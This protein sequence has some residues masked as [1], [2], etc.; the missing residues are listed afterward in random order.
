VFFFLHKLTGKMPVV[1]RWE[2]AS[3]SVDLA[4]LYW[5]MTLLDLLSIY[6]HM[7]KFYALC[8]ILLFYT[9][10]SYSNRKYKYVQVWIWV[11]LKWVTRSINYRISLNLVYS[12][13][14]ASNYFKDNAYSNYILKRLV[15]CIPISVR[16]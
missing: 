5:K 14:Y 7:E 4:W 1:A 9:Q 16:F 2:E 13:F 8:I 3:K 11:H 6:Q 12:V 15:V 10:L